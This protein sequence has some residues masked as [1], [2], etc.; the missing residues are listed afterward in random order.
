MAAD[1]EEGLYLGREVPFDVAIIDLGLP[2]KS[3]MELIQDLRRRRMA[4]SDPHP[5]RAHQ[6]A[7]QS[8][9]PEA[10]RGR[11][12]GE[13]VSRR[14]TSCPTQCAGAPR[15][16]RPSPRSECGPIVLDTTARD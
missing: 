14:R 3:G 16:C 11:L 10:R 1:G 8:A 7:R 13:T 15:G 2:R 6:L 4:L 9:S 5:H 12:S